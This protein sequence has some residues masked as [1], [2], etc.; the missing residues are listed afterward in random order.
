MEKS[1][2]VKNNVAGG[3]HDANHASVAG[4]M[5]GG[6]LTEENQIAVCDMPIDPTVG[7]EPMNNVA[8]P[9][10]DVTVAVCNM[11]MMD[12]TPVMTEMKHITGIP[13]STRKFF[14]CNIHS[15]HP[16]KSSILASKTTLLLGWIFEHSEQGVQV[17]T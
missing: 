4:D 13:L 12:V 2:Y 17:T 9:L 3:S 5:L 7:D 11:P 14:S 10:N 15:L 6:T 8:R 1:L 16:G